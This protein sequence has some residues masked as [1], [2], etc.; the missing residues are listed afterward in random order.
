VN[1]ED[2]D[3]LY[4]SIKTPLSDTVNLELDYLK[5]ETEVYDNPQSPSYPALSYLSTANLISAGKGGNPFGVPVMWIGR[6]L[7]SAFPSP[8][9]PRE[10]EMD[11][12]SFGLSGTYDNGFD[13]DFHITNSS[14]DN[15][16]SQP[17]TGTSK[18]AAAIDGTGG[19]TGDQT[20][21]LFDPS[22][23]SQELRDWLRSD[24]E[25]WTD[26]ELSVIDYVV[27]GQVGNVNMAIGLQ[28]RKEV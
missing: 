11:R 6:P 7:A 1:D 4:F 27:S 22:A 15:Y 5:A 26:V 12:L 14:E 21:N 17:D 3:Q 28:T 23:N 10:I 9:A 13:W 20:F 8:F 24:Q 2:H 25:T 16:G 18:L 19:S